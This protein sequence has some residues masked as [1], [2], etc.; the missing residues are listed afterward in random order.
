MNTRSCAPKNRP[1]LSAAL[2]RQIREEYQHDR[3]RQ[4][5]LAAKH[6]V[7]QETIREIVMFESYPDA[8]GP[9]PP[10]EA[11]RRSRAH[12]KLTPSEALTAKRLWWSVPDLTWR[13]VAAKIGRPEAV[14]SVG[15]AIAGVNYA[16]LEREEVIRS[17]PRKPCRTVADDS[18]TE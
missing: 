2:A 7:S 17:R 18:M 9:L 12:A 1:R 13:E 8:G 4:T 11:V 14:L 6:H 15:M 5:D 3:V 10:P 16:W